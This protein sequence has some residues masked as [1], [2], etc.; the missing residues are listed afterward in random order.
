MVAVS[1]MEWG[2]MG[3]VGWDTLAGRPLPVGHEG[4]AL[5]PQRATT[6][7]IKPSDNAQDLLR[8]CRR[9]LVMG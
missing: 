1:G 7:Q 2:G 3:W 5:G 8:L 9:G 4:S 6:A